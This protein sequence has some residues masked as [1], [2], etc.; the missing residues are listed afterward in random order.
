MIWSKIKNV[1]LKNK[2]AYLTGFANFGSIGFLNSINFKNNIK[3]KANFKILK[4]IQEKAAILDLDFD[5]E[6][7]SFASVVY[8]LKTICFEIKD[9]G[10]PM[11]VAINDS[12]LDYDWHFLEVLL[13]KQ[14]VY[15]YLD[16]NLIGNYTYKSKLESVKAY[17]GNNFIIDFSNITNT[18]GLIIKNASITIDN[19]EFLLNEEEL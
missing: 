8:D 19:E 3:V 13:D 4:D 5:P 7:K 2:E 9:G 15:F 10:N 18:I 1:E 14:T 16:R 17:F 11:N 12:P 6:N